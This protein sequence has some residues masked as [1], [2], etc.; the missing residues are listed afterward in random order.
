MQTSVVP[1]LARTLGLETTI[2]GWAPSAEFPPDAEGGG[3]CTGLSRDPG[4]HPPTR[5]KLFPMH[6][7]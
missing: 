4:I 2:H 3:V 6:V 7:S 1:G 5:S